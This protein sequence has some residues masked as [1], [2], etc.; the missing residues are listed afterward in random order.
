LSIAVAVDDILGLDLVVMLRQGILASVLISLCFRSGESQSYGNMTYT[1][2]GIIKKVHN[3][4]HLNSNFERTNNNFNIDPNDLQNEYFESLLV[5]PIIFT[6]LIFIAFSIF[7]LALCCRVCCP[8]CRCVDSGP[9]RT[10]I[11]SMALWTEKVTNSRVSLIRAFWSFVCLSFLACQGII[12]AGI[13]FLMGSS[14]GIDSANNLY[15]IAIV[16]K[17]SGE[18]LEVSGEIILNLTARA[19]PTCP[20]ASYVQNYADD[21]DQYVTDYQDIIDPIPN[22]LNHLEDFLH[23]YGIEVASIAVWSTYSIVSL[24]LIAIVVTY[25]F[26]NKVAMKVSIASTNI[27]L[28]ALLFGWCLC[29]ISMVGDPPPPLSPSPLARPSPLHRW[30]SLISVWPQQI[31]PSLSPLTVLLML[32]LIMGPVMAPIHLMSHSRQPM[33]P[34]TISMPPSLSLFNQAACVRTMLIS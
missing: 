33:R 27:I 31:M 23:T 32:R 3:L 19:I 24:C 22:D 30:V 2:L 6:S 14:R 34:L 5:L 12:A 13:F 29:M 25:L 4:P 15:D 9:L 28:H 10:S 20:E 16:L 17:D 7:G 11:H 26:K 8:C 18:D 1:P 21:F